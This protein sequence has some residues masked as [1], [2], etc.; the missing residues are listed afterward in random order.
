MSSFFVLAMQGDTCADREFEIGCDIR[1]MLV[2]G[3]IW[4]GT[5]RR[6]LLM[7]E[8]YRVLVPWVFFVD[9]TEEPICL[10]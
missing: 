8:F 3:L 6:F 7:L 5:L 4:M 9:I 1:L 10:C 2:E